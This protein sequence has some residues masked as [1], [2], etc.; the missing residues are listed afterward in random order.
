L[1]LFEQTLQFIVVKYH[2]AIGF[3]II[4]GWLKIS[5]VP[6]L[7]AENYISIKDIIKID[8]DTVFFDMF[9]LIISYFGY[10]ACYFFLPGQRNLLKISIAFL[11]AGMFGASFNKYIYNHGYDFIEIEYMA[12]F[13]IKDI[14]IT[15]WSST[16]FLLLV[17]AIPFLKK[18]KNYKQKIYEYFKWELAFWRDLRLKFKF[19]SD[20]YFK[21]QGIAK[22]ARSRNFIWPEKEK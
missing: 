7:H 16:V 6:V 19:F 4:D 2:D 13:D 17:E 21:R 3:T 15:L 14:Y 9:I 11:F 8:L 5:P 22:N 1:V 18:V 12:V 10:R 20:K